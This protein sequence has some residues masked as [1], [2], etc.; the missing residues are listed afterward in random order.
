MI[1]CTTAHE[2]KGQVE[3][4][5]LGRLARELDQQ[6]KWPGQAACS[7]KLTSVMIHKQIP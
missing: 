2:N 1:V 5:L 4:A 7:S 6:L 3:L